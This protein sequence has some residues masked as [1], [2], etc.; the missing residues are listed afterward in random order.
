MS[1]FSGRIQETFWAVILSTRKDNFDV[2]VRFSQTSPKI[3][4]GA[5][6]KP[7]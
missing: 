2:E 7:L 5:V 4:V 6:H 1:N 3:T